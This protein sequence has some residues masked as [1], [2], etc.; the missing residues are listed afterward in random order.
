MVGHTGLLFLPFLLFLLL[1]GCCWLPW[2]CCQPTSHPAGTGPVT[3]RCHS[4]V[5][6]PRRVPRGAVEATVSPHAQ[7]IMDLPH[8]TPSTSAQKVLL[9]LLLAGPIFSPFLQTPVKPGCQ[10]PGAASGM[11]CALLRSVHGAGCSV[12]P[13]FRQVSLSSPTSPHSLQGLS[14]NRSQPATPPLPVLF[15]PALFTVCLL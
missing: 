13:L 5:Q 14:H 4:L 7:T 11:N 10:F 9:P 2:Q 6:P 3:C 8:C 15:L 1:L 12:S